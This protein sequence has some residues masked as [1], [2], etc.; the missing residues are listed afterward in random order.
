M[1]EHLLSLLELL[2]RKASEVGV[3]RRTRHF[4]VMIDSMFWGNMGK[5][6][7]FRTEYLRVF[8]LKVLEL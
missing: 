8:L 1:E 4:D 5:L 2:W 6:I 3:H 7:K